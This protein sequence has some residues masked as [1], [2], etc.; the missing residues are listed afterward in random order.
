MKR[1]RK[2]LRR[3]PVCFINLSVAI[4]SG[5]GWKG[6]WTHAGRERTGEMLRWSVRNR[7]KRENVSREDT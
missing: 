1:Q 7:K 3:G 6:Q 5:L 4:P 2:K